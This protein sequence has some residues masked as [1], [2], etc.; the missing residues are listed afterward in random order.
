[1]RAAL[2]ALVV[3][4]Q[5]GVAE[6]RPQPRFEPT[7]LELEEPGVTEID[8]Q[9]G[10]VRGQGPWK[11]VTP[12]FE[13]DLGL[14]PRL[15]L[16]LDG[17]WAFEGVTPGSPGSTL[18]DHTAPDNLWLSAKIGIADWRDPER[19]RAVAIGLQVGPKLPV[20]NGASGLGL[21]VLALVGSVWSGSHLVIN[22]GGLYDPSVMGGRPRGIEAGLDLELELVP[23][24]W[25][26]LGELGGVSYV[27][28]DPN[29]L[30]GTA[31]LQFSPTKMLD[32]SVVFLVG[33]LSGSD[34]YGL[35]FG[36]SPKFALW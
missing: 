18:F 28:S 27:S 20:A 3:A 31:G 26:I 16:D 9:L 25:S 7:D 19:D 14:L 22:F 33:F 1:M 13:I 21:E 34:Q 11:L 24:R 30:S 15:E 23:D 29:Q 8:L 6:A 17:A 2:A 5:P 10:P 36:A 35:L 32:L 4:A 12:D